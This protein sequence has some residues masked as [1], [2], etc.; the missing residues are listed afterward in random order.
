MKFKLNVHGRVFNVFTG[1]ATFDRVYVTAYKASVKVTTYGPLGAGL[2]TN[3]TVLL[4][5]TVQSIFLAT[6]VVVV[7]GAEV[8]VVVVGVISH[9][10]G[11]HHRRYC[12]HDLEVGI[13]RQHALKLSNM[14]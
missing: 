10:I 4:V 8:V 7:V 11:D 2:A 1:S 14:L 6:V 3:I 9:F 13:A 12:S 5:S